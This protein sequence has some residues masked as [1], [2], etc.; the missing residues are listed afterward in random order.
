MKKDIGCICHDGLSRR[1]LL[2]VGTGGCGADSAV[3]QQLAHI[4]AADRPARARRLPSR[5][6]GNFEDLR[7]LLAMILTRLHPRI[8]EIVP[9]HYSKLSSSFMSDSPHAHQFR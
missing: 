1:E 2:R 8:L 5:A 7:L 3:R 9:S 6:A 4:T